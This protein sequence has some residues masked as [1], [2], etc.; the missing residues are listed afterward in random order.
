MKD[1]DAIDLDVTK[2]ATK[3]L[4][5]FGTKQAK[6]AHAT[7]FVLENKA[8]A[9][10]ES[11]ILFRTLLHVFKTTLARIR[12]SEGPV[13]NGELIRRLFQN[14]VWCLTM[15]DGRDGGKEAFEMLMQVFHEIKPHIF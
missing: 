14:F 8:K 10:K 2:P 9:L 15:Y 4:T 5:L 11:K 6:P 7:A 1:I 13:P 12:T 3:K